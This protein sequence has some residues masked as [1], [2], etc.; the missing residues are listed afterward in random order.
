MLAMFWRQ[1]DLSLEL[2]PGVGHPLL[3]GAFPGD[4]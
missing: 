4:G 2:V 1:E 3:Q